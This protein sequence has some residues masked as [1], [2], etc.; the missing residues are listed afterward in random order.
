MLP[1]S[2][3]GM[4]RFLFKN[5]DL[6][7]SENHRQAYLQDCMYKTLSAILTDRLYRLP[8]LY[9]LIDSCQEGF[10]KVHSTQ[11]QVQSLH[12][13]FEEALDKEKSCM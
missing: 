2:L 1:A 12:L 8:E 10:R 4:I 13:A 6:L 11:L 3:G 7:D 9:G 5:E